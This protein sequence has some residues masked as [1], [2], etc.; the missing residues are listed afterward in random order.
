M[1]RPGLRATVKLSKKRPPV[2]DYAESYDYTFH[3]HK[4]RVTLP[5]WR[6]WEATIR[7]MPDPCDFL[8]GAAGIVYDY[9]AFGDKYEMTHATIKGLMRLLGTT[10]FDSIMSADDPRSAAEAWC[11]GQREI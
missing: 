2:G 6:S 11:R 8:W 5:Y 7:P 9:I 1:L 3:Y 4:R 10:S